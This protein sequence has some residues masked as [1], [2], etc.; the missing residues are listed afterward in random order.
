[1]SGDSAESDDGKA[2]EQAR[3]QELQAA[4]DKEFDLYEKHRERLVQGQL[5]GEKGYDTLLVT[6]SSAALGGSAF[7]L[8]GMKRGSGAAALI[9]IAWIA[10]C[11]CLGSS[12]L[13]AL[14]TYLSHKRSR[15]IYD[16]HF[17]KW[18]EPGAWAAAGRESDRLW[19]RRVLRV[20]KWL[21]LCA[22]VV[23][24]IPL[25]IAFFVTWGAQANDDNNSAAPSQLVNVHTSP[26][27]P[28]MQP[29]TKEKP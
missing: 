6:L 27:Q 16:K 20:T 12:L 9:G 3:L 28:A 13:D 17:E 26:A 18:K 29:T 8:Q 2:R 22:L 7:V 11:I 14:L 4:C 1:M 24:V 23:G 25:F 10:L 15:E 19:H 5:E 21:G